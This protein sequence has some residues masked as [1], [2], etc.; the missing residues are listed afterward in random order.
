MHYVRTHTHTCTNTLIYD[1]RYNRWNGCVY[2][3]LC[4]SA[5]CRFC[6]YIH[7]HLQ[8]T[9][10]TRASCFNPSRGSNGLFSNKNHLQHLPSIQQIFINQLLLFKYTSHYSTLVAGMQEA[11][12]RII[13][14]DWE[15]G[16]G[17]ECYYCGLGCGSSSRNKNE[18]HA[19]SWPGLL[20][21]NVS[22]TLKHPG[23]APD[24][25]ISPYFHYFIF[26]INQCYCIGHPLDQSVGF[27]NISS[28]KSWMKCP[29][30]P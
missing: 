26:F 19:D 24:N 25:I 2:L 17:W 27:T 28:M 16:T 29:V 12:C 9:C 22:I 23:S 30:F 10:C 20:S 21:P 13:R 3:F 8:N 1:R 4:P 7:P 18:S 6:I 14:V 15:R 5:S 11:Q